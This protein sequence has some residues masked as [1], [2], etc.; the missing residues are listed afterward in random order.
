VFRVVIATVL[1]VFAAYLAYGHIASWTVYYLELQAPLAFLTAAGVLMT[2]KLIAPR[3][4]RRGLFH[5]DTAMAQRAVFLTGAALLLAPAIGEAWSSRTSH[6]A[7]RALVDAFDETIR[8][9][10]ARPAIAFVR[11]RIDLHPERTVVDNVVDLNAAPLWVVHDR[12]SDN[13]S[14]GSRAPNRMSYLITEV[15]ERDSV[16]FRVTE[17]DR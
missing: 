11:E 13:G 17:L 2:A 1:G 4:S 10:G 6:L 12:G 14:L 7:D 15:R 3:L 8:T 16:A 5:N 9:L